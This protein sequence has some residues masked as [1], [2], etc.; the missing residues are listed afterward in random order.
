MI[1]QS[2]CSRR[3]CCNSAVL[4]RRV[5]WWPFDVEPSHSF[6]LQ[7]PNGQPKDVESIEHDDQQS[8]E[9]SI[10]LRRGAFR[11]GETRVPWPLSSR[12]REFDLFSSWSTRVGKRRLRLDL[13]NGSSPSVEEG[14][15]R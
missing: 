9:A 1:I 3:A 13:A 15:N 14:K 7:F 8:A 2:T 6:L 4:R 12:V 11:H 5:S 10:R